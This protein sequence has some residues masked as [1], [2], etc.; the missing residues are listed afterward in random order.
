MFIARLA[1]L[2]LL[3]AMVVLVGAWLLTRNPRYLEW[4]RRLLRV[5][6]VFAV[7][8]MVLYLAERLMFI[9]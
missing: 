8:V 1:G 4:A 3:I 7:V 5:A 2:L 6:V 9:L